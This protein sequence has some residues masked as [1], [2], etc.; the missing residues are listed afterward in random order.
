MASLVAALLSCG[1]AAAQTDP[2]RIERF[3][4]GKPFGP[5]K[6]L[7]RFTVG[8]GQKRPVR[9][10]RVAFRLL[11]G[12]KAVFEKA[13]TEVPSDV[14]MDTT[15]LARGEYRVSLVRLDGPVEEPLDEFVVEVG[16]P[17]VKKPRTPDLSSE[18]TPP[19]V[20]IAPALRFV[21]RHTDATR[22]PVSGLLKIPVNGIATLAPEVF[23]AVEI[24]K[25]GKLLARNGEIAQRPYTFFWDTGTAADGEYTLKLVALDL[26]SERQTESD[27]LK[28]VV[29]NP[30]RTL[31]A[32]SGR[33]LP[34]PGSGGMAIP[35]PPNWR[36]SRSGPGLL[37]TGTDAVLAGSNA[38]KFALIEAL[39]RLAG[40]P[41]PRVAA[42]QWALESSW[43]KSVSGKN[44][45]FGIKAQP[46][47]AGTTKDT[48]EFYNGVP[49]SEIARFA[50]YNSPFECLQARLTFLRK[51]HYSAYWK[52]KTDEEACFSLQSAGYATD[53]NYASK[54]IDIIAR[55]AKAK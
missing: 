1:L 34:A 45:Y 18:P 3:P 53:P 13:V 11:Q 32:P 4:D 47:E 40:D 48:T 28:L 7:V 24:W 39:S 6:G 36:G 19:P 14:V 21:T 29:K 9:G 55:M 35:P 44:N 20:P 12:E 54:L 27:S 31:I 5:Y 49:T 42:A 25:Q 50:D 43:G 41:R 15:N 2:I 8:R 22:P 17:E 52:S 51:S 33:S 16:E 46:G 30:R 38:D 10:A 26:A 23:P 37:L